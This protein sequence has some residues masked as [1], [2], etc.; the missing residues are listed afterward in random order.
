MNFTVVPDFLAIG[1]LTAVFWAM[2]KRTHQSRLRYWLVG[3][4]LILVHIAAQFVGD[5]ISDGADLAQAVSVIMLV[6]TSMAFIWAGSGMRRSD[7]R[8][9]GMTLLS[10]APDAVLCALVVFS[11]DAKMPYYAVTV[12]GWLTGLWVFHG[13]R[14]I[15]ARRNLARGLLIT[16]I[17]GVQA[18]LIWRGLLVQTL[19]WTLFAHYMAAAASF[20]QSSPRAR[21]G[22]RFT[23]ISF[24]AWALVFPAAMLMRYLWP[25]VHVESEVWN[26]PKFLVATG[27]IVTMLEEHMLEAEH[28][29]LHD[30]LTGLPNRRLFLRRLHRALDEARSQNRPVALLVIDLNDFKEVNDELG[31]AVG[32]ELLRQIAQ[33]FSSCLRQG[34]TLARLGGDEFA[35]ILTDVADRK[36]AQTVVAK[37]HA[38]L[39]TPIS[40]DGHSLSRHTSIG[41]SMYPDDSIDQ[42]RLYALADRRMYGYKQE[43]RLQ[44]TSPSQQA[45]VPQA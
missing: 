7:T 17:Y 45:T 38:A 22:R 11:V 1:G 33:R 3:W 30:S 44:A 42:T 4:M 43:A 21:I 15:D 32:D 41:L 9:L 31:H 34:D 14:G 35:S 10:A 25:D 12:L 16:L 37:L 39:E 36:S 6:L 5:N 8:T 27:M 20:G 29:S 18:V 26:L 24:V 28:A 23:T 2:L 40:I 19:I 13:Q